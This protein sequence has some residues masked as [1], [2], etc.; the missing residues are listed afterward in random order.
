MPRELIFFIVNNLTIFIN[1]QIK[2][3]YIFI[4]KYMKYEGHKNGKK[5]I[6]ISF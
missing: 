3:D 2:D 6:E 4:H 5:S 1:K